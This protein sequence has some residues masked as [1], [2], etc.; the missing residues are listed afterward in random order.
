MGFRLTKISEHSN[1]KLAD[2]QK[3]YLVEE[4]K[5][6]KKREEYHK[7]SPA[8]KQMYEDKISGFEAALTWFGYKIVEQKDVQETR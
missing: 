5:N 1:M 2:W 8:L 6:M 3:E 7:D 4:Y